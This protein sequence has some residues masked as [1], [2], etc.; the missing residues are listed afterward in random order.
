MW[1]K[2]CQL[3]L[4]SSPYLN[5]CLKDEIMECNEKYYYKLEH[6]G[7]WVVCPVCPTMAGDLGVALEVHRTVVTGKHQLQKDSC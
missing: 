2:V 7:G 3:M 5:F 4:E 1:M 6:T